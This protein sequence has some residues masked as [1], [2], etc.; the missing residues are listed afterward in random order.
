MILTCLQFARNM[1]NQN[2]VY[3]ERKKTL[4]LRAKNIEKILG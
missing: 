1:A 2:E 3:Q 4:V